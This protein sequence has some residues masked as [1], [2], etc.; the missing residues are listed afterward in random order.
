MNNHKAQYSSAVYWAIVCPLYDTFL[1]LP[2]LVRE[3]GY[4]SFTV[5][6]LTVLTCVIA[7]VVAIAVACYSDRV[8]HRFSYI[9]ICMLIIAVG[10]NLHLRLSPRR[11]PDVVYAGA[12]IFIARL[13]HLFCFPGQCPLTFE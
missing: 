1:V 12:G 4:T 13:N 11:V 9:F 10:H 7:A 5:Q 2:S 6:L 8:G 3:L